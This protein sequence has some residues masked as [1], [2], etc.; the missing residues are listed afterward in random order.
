[1]TSQTTAGPARASI[2]F[3]AIGRWDAADLQRFVSAVAAMYGLMLVCTG[4]MEHGPDVA[5][6]FRRGVTLREDELL[7]FPLTIMDLL[8]P[9]ESRAAFLRQLQLEYQNHPADRLYVGSI[10]IADPGSAVF[11]GV[12]PVI[13]QL[14]EFVKQLWSRTQEERERQ[15][16]GERGVATP[17][18][19][20]MA[21]RVAQ[22]R[23]ATDYLRGLQ[24]Y[25][26]LAGQSD[27][28]FLS[29][30]AAI[31]A[32]SVEDLDDLVAAG[33]ILEAP[34]HLADAE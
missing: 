7:A 24:C 28:R 31:F 14:R 26:D 29:Q 20:Q 16:Q 9:E 17:W 30:A 18:D 25:L 15:E 33:R 19:A 4:A 10:Q 27:E 6:H 23:F 13:Q 5:A 21:L 32:H 22:V 11:A 1:M 3:Y 34:E 2:A 12:E 8:R